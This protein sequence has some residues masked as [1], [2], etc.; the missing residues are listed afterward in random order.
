MTL[1]ALCHEITIITY[2]N[3]LFSSCRLRLLL[4][5][6]YMNKSMAGF[7]TYILA[8]ISVLLKHKG[9]KLCTAE[10]LPRKVVSNI[11]ECLSMNGLQKS[12]ST[13][14]TWKHSPDRDCSSFP[15][16]GLLLVI[17]TSSNILDILFCHKTLTVHRL[18]SRSVFSL[19]NN[20]IS[21]SSQ[22]S[23]QILSG[24]I[25][26]PFWISFH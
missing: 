18:D 16:A 26:S 6:H 17:S 20:I 9:Y 21:C 2:V 25:S 14:P 11:R 5:F 3:L 19:S 24:D 12:A 13:F 1:N 8:H 4:I 15:G 23:F 22:S 7:W 10:V